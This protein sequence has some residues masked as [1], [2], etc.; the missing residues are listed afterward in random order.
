MPRQPERCIVLS[1]LTAARRRAGR[2][3]SF[4]QSAARLASVLG[5]A[6]NCCTT[7]PGGARRRGSQQCETAV[8]WVIDEA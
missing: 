6:E 5:P 8:S 7:G 4:Q 2:L 1:A 3:R